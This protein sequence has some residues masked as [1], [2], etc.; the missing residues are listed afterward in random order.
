MIEAVTIFHE[1]ARAKNLFFEPKI[2]LVKRG[3]KILLQLF[4]CHVIPSILTDILEFCPLHRLKSAVRRKTGSETDKQQLFCEK[5]PKSLQIAV[6]SYFFSVL[7]SR[8][9][10][11]CYVSLLD[12]QF[13]RNTQRFGIFA[14][15]KIWLSPAAL[16]ANRYE[17][18]KRKADSHRFPVSE[19]FILFQDRDESR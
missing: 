17:P 18:G 19:K 1:L 13:S 6:Q 11:C 2:I 9:V 12:L 16:L 5:L 10:F 15:Q 8:I 4:M 14:L 7:C 3:L